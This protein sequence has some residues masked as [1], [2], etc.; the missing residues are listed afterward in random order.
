ME[1]M[2]S[3]A[4]PH[5]DR[6]IVFRYSRGRA[7]V[8]FLV[9]AAVAIGLITFARMN[10]AWIAYYVAGA[11]ILVLLVFQK[12]LTARFHSANWLMRLTDD[13]LF[14]KFRSYLNNHF[15]DED[16]TVVFIPYAEIRSAKLVKQS[17]EVPDQDGKRQTTTVRTQRYVELE[18][19]GDTRRLAGALA[20]ETERVL[21]KSNPSGARVSTRYQHLPVRLAAASLLRVEWGVVPSAATLM[22]SLTRHTMVRPESETSTHVSGLETASRAK[23]ETRLLD[24]AQSGD[25]IGAVTL[26]RRL[27]GY[28]LAKAKDFVDSLVRTQSPR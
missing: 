14:I 11:L 13:G 15:A 10:H 2:R 19:A 27:Y 6:D 25:L 26:A 12:V 18:L 8:T 28:D 23:Q 7:L 24:L 22:E 1:L 16:L 3:A 21:G 4:V 20:L 17:Q 5:N 9:L